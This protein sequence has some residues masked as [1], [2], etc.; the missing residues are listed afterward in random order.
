MM[1]TLN[2]DIALAPILCVLCGSMLMPAFERLAAALRPY[3]EWLARQALWVAI[4]KL[5][6]MLF[7]WV[8]ILIAG[9]GIERAAAMW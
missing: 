9:I 7:W 3:L 8:G 4:R 1:D 5:A 6:W 2:S